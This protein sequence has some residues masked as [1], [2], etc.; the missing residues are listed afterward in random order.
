MTVIV[1]LNLLAPLQDTPR[2]CHERSGELFPRR[3]R[4]GDALL[5]QNLRVLAQ[6][7][8]LH[9]GPGERPAFS[10][11]ERSSHA[12]FVQREEGTCSGSDVLNGLLAAQFS[13]QAESYISM[14]LDKEELARDFEISLKIRTYDQDGLLFASIVRLK[15]T[16]TMKAD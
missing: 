14:K 16:L 10:S 12:D 15:M 5:Q 3:D 1:H 7:A 2:D 6:V 9:S 11:G 4:E 8:K 13:R